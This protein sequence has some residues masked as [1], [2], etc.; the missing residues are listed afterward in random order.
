VLIRTPADLGAIIR[1]RRRRLGLDQQTL[2][3]R[4]GV[5]RQWVLGVEKGKSGAAM[6]IVLRALSILGITLSVD[7]ELPREDA[8]SAPNIDAVVK[9]ARRKRS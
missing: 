3:D 7:A 6:G 8:I 1:D 4:L 9:E 2:A 5:T